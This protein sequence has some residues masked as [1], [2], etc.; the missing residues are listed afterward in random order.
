MTSFIILLAVVA[1]SALGH[2][3]LK[4]G[5]NS[6]GEISPDRINQPFRL[7]S[8]FLTTPAILI[9]LPLYLAGFIGWVLVLSR[10]NLSLAYPALALTYI[11]IPFAAWLFLSEPISRLH[12]AGIVIISGGMILV[13]RGGTS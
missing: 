13:I 8:D 3:L 7:M 10:I 1:V 9:A 6:I 4:A 12:W 11:L 5:V 2:V